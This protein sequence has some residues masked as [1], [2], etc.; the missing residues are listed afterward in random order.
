MGYFNDKIT[1]ALCIF[2]FQNMNQSELR[3][4]IER[5]KSV[6][7]ADPQYAPL[8]HEIYALF[9]QNEAILYGPE[10][11]V[12]IDFQALAENLHGIA[13]PQRLEQNPL[14]E[15]AVGM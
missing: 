13:F 14:P 11:K 9:I 8:L 2:S 3:Q 15:E 1:N 5:L 7:Q 10:Y 6:V 12:D 4:V